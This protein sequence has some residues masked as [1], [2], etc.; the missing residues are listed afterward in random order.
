LSGSI[1]GN[2]ILWDKHSGKCIH[3]YKGHTGSIFDVI[4]LSN[5]RIASCSD[6]W[7]I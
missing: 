1:F 2:V 6:D 4:F 7:S 5:D 3:T